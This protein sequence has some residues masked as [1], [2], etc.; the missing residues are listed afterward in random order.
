MQPAGIAGQRS[1]RA[2]ARLA[3]PERTLA[4]GREVTRSPVSADSR[5]WPHGTG[6]C[7][8]N[9]PKQK[10]STMKHVKTITVAK[11]AVNLPDVPGLVKDII[12]QV[13][14]AFQKG[15]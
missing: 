9:Q 12:N 2:R 14:G 3:L 10:G 11:A 13:I 8:V 15:A 6:R 7:G 4:F 5:R 1:S